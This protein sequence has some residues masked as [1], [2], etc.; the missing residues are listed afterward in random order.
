MQ[1]YFL[2][3]LGYFQ[4]INAVDAFV[5]YDNVEYTKKGWINRN[6]YLLNREP[7]WFTL[8]IVK[9]S[10]FLEIRERKLV[11]DFQEK[12]HKLFRTL[13]G[14]YN[15]SPNFKTLSSFLKEILFYDSDN[16]F[17]YIYNSIINVNKYLEIDTK[18]II[19][20]N[21][22][23]PNQRLFGKAR[24]MNLCKIIGASEYINPIGGIELYSKSEFE[25]EGIRLRFHRMGEVKYTQF[26]NKFVPNL[27]IIDMLMFVD[28][29]EI[30]KELFN[31]I[32][33]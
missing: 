30:K 5:I 28:L 26:E 25:R 12:M 31:Y 32:I 10:D 29:H 7:E 14:S 6:R 13:E 19:S 27:S 22:E 33:E 18:L 24:V 1:P 9:D 4:L 15:K 21:V 23:N 20:S 8:P 3:Y 11:P 16:L 2:P 17:D